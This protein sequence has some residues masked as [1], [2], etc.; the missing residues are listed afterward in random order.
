MSSSKVPSCTRPD[1]LLF[2]IIALAVITLLSLPVYA[3]PI[4][5]YISTESSTN[6][7]PITAALYEQQGMALMAAHDMD[8]LLALTDKGLSLYL[9]DAELMCL[10]AYALRKTGHY[11]ESVDLLNVAIPMDP[12][13]ARFVN[14]GYGL[15][16]MGK[17]EEALADADKAIMMNTSYSQGHGLKAEVLLAMGNFT[18][19]L[20]EADAALALDPGAAH[21]WHVRGNVLD[22]KGDCDGAIESLRK[23]LDLKIEYDM[24]W[25]G[26]PNV[27]VDLAR[28]MNRCGNPKTTPAPT[29]AALPGILVVAGIGIVVGLRR[30]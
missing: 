23:S 29:K 28:V 8:G 10:K 1:I 17:T 21:Y 13:P 25:P 15:L 24:P 7:P 11:Q 27:S 26:L 3:A 22:R 30:R 14:R 18:G 20:Q 5:A 16:A 9:D 19:A 6:L 2:S 12:R 4:T